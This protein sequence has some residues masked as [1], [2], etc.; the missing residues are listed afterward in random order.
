MLDFIENRLEAEEIENVELKL[1]PRDDPQ[2][3]A[4]GVDAILMVDTLHYVKDRVAYDFLPE[5]YFV[6]YAAK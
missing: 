3:P 2:L 5:Q 6:V 1:V 4:G